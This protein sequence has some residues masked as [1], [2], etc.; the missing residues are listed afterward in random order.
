MTGSNQIYELSNLRIFT[1]KNNW[2]IAKN[3]L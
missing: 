1:I 2:F 3:I